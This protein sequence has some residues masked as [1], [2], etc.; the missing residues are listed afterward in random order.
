MYFAK[1]GIGSP[2]TRGDRIRRALLVLGVACTTGM[3][4]A[5]ES[6]LTDAKD[7]AKQTPT[8][9]DAAFTY[10]RA[11]RRAGRE[12]DAL[13]ELRRGQAFAQGPTAVKLT[14]EV[15][16]TYIAKRDFQH[17]MATCRGM[18][19]L[20]N[21]NAASHACA[22]EAH[23]LWRRGSEAMTEIAEVNKLKDV[24]ADV[25]YAVKVAEGRA[26][27]LESKEG[28]AEVAYREAI[29]LA[30]DRP[31]AH[32]LLGVM[33]HRLAKE[34]L[35][36]LKKAVELDPHDPVAQLELG[37][38][39]P[40]GGADAIGAFEKAVAERPT[41]TDALRSLT[42]AYL[43]AKR[44]PDAKKTAE[45]VL[46]IAPNDVYS[47]IAQG[48]VALAEGR[49]D[50]AL[51]EGETAVKAMPN[52]G[53]AKLLV[54][55]AYAKKN[56][57]DLALEAYQAAYGLDHGDPAPLVN[58]TYACIAAGRNTSAKAFARRATVDFANHAP[59][60][61]A[62]GDALA[63]DKEKA[64]AKTAYESAKKARDV[65]VA[66]VDKKIANLK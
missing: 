64:A 50:D 22:A 44:I 33:L 5:Q 63:A 38:A 31:D 52:E 13:N 53:K 41:Y 27:E 24:P 45:A 1:F 16:R 40:V 37:R 20:T 2:R 32:M 7:K 8:S 51:K 36:S 18:Q 65:D 46:K 57:V 4:G 17:A 3:A 30:A 6:A 61:I 12:T 10:G 47:R 23:L 48:R 35:P 29:K 43:A 54:A 21:A 60:W 56:E 26:R 34:G 14:W 62:L 42:E 15:A 58:A 9:P 49:A 19:R 25:S 59:A 66:A 28:D 55:D 11:L 39:Y